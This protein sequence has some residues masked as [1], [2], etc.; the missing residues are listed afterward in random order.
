MFVMK[1]QCVCVCVQAESEIK[2]VEPKEWTKK[3]W[4]ERKHMYARVSVLHMCIEAFSY[5]CMRLH[6]GIIWC[7]LNGWKND[8]NVQQAI[9]VC[10]CVCVWLRILVCKEIRR[11]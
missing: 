11:F 2:Q 10:V 8:D 3:Q 5:F 7:N 6:V 9:C 1:R 4:Q